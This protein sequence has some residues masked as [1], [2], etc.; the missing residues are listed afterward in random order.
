MNFSKTTS[1]SLN[2]LSYMA[3]HENLRM[4]ASYLHGRLKIPY[5]YLRAILGEL[6]RKRLIEGMKGRNGGFKL[7]RDKSII[8]LAD[9]IEATEGLESF[10]KCI[11]GFDKCPFDYGCLMHPIWIKMRADILNVL[12]KTSLDIM[13]SGKELTY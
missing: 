4:S 9:I 10:S 12:K 7:S 1:Y 2:V 3:K 11:M 13:L 8:F 6:S 5:P